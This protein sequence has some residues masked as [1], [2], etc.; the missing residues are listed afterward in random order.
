MNHNIYIIY[1]KDFCNQSGI[2]LHSD[3]EY[4]VLVTPEHLQ[5]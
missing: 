5:S 3:I 2:I 4:H 1:I